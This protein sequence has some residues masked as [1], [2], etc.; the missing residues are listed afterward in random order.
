MSPIQTGTS[1]HPPLLPQSGSICI[2]LH[3]RD[4]LSILQMLTYPLFHCHPD[5][6]CPQKQK[7]MVSPFLLGSFSHRA[8]Q[9]HIL[10]GQQ[11]EGSLGKQFESFQTRYQGMFRRLSAE[12][13]IC[14]RFLPQPPNWPLLPC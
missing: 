9:W 12:L 10:Y 1:I 5:C 3:I 8:F 7:K 4:G 11:V 6:R 13:S 2:H 14:G